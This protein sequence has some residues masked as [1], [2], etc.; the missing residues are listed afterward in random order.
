M[1]PTHARILN[2]PIWDG[3]PTIAPLQGGI[4]NES[5]VVTDLAGRHVVRIGQDFPF[6]HVERDRELMTA[7]AAFAAGFAAPV[8][9]AE[10]GLTVVRF[11]E[12]RTYTPDDMRCEIDRIAEIVR[13]FHTTMGREV[14]GPGYIFWP[15]HVIRDY[16][17]TLKASLHPLVARVPALLDIN[18]RLEAAQA[19]LPIIFGHHDFL[20][21]NIIDD[22]KRLWIID[23]EYAGFGTAMFDLAN[24]SSNSGFS[25]AQ[26][27]QLL[28]GYFGADLTDE[29]RRSHAA[30]QCASLLREA[31]WSL[32]SEMF[33]SVAGAD[34]DAYARE[35]FIRFD[36]ALETYRSTYESA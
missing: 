25:A 31:M 29:L 33:M 36:A 24:I 15:F 2:L 19:P 4:S 30:M 21:A 11:I 8:E 5:Y 18:D 16:S 27:E 9:H 14:R 20:P 17:E 28:Q 6:H 13:R 3:D 35:N 26:S 32:V 10:P 7:R 12:G 22:G 34:Y 23:Y 1:N